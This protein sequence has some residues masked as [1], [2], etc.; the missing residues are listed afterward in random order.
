MRRTKSSRDRDRDLWCET[1]LKVYLS[2]QTP[3]TYS[4]TGSKHSVYP[5]RKTH[6]MSIKLVGLCRTLYETN[7]RNSRVNKMHIDVK[8]ILTMEN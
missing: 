5:V 7:L 2:L 4:A 8:R 6:A 3:T 1:F